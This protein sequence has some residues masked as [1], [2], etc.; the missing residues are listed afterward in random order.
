VHSA[1]QD[2]D[3]PLRALWLDGWD[4]E[5]PFVGACCGAPALIMKEAGLENV[6]K[7]LGREEN[8]NWKSMAWE[9]S[10]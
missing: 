6:A 10:P 3:Q 2:G 8:A 1:A 7:D 9:V 4:D 5:A